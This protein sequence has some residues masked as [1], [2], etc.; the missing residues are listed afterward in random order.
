MARLA[1][2]DSPDNQRIDYSLTLL[3]GVGWALSKAIL[4]KAD[5]NPA[6]KTRD[7]TEEEFSKLTKTVEGYTIEGD[8]RRSIRQEIQRLKDIS[9]YRGVRHNRGLPSRGQRTRSNARTKRGKR[10]TVGAFKKEALSKQTQTAAK[11]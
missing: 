11:K 4:N 5:V 1:G 6:T 10:K 9:S 3:Y 7:L 8:L 2:I